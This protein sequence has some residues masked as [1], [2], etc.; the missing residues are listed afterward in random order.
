M[1]AA[2]K[3]KT[4][5][6]TQGPIPIYVQAVEAQPHVYA[7]TRDIWK[8]GLKRHAAL[9]KRLKPTFAWDTKP[10]MKALAAAEIIISGSR[11]DRAVIGPQTPNLK[12]L[13]VTAAGVEKLVPL[14]W[15]PKG[16]VLTNASGVHG[17]K[18]GEFAVMALL[19]LNDR[20]PLH[21]DDQKARRWNQVFS[22]PIAG[23]TAVIVGVGAIGEECARRAKQLGLHVIGVRRSGKAARYVDRTVSSKQIHRVLPKAD[24]LLVI[25]PLTR[26][27]R[28]LIG[29]RELELLKPGAGLINMGRGP[30]VDYAALAELLRSGRLGGA[31]LDVFE[32]EP[33]PPESPLWTVPRLLVTPHVS[34][35]DPS[36]YAA[37]C[38]DVFFANLKEYLRG[39]DLPNRVDGALG[40]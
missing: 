38:L 24:F 37:R 40:Y 23:K 27:T 14:D 17:P 15:L 36:R 32:P 2:R 16:A 29:R 30:V 12:W 34:S 4:A 18:S 26:E 19:M 10:D 8:A 28:G 9:A 33:L 1:P 31:I 21:I 39:R 20:M 25:T 5:A 6:R 3:T 22:S 7:I 35:D 13:H 11:V